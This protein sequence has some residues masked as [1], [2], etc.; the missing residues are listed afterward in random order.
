MTDQIGVLKTIPLLRQGDF[1]DC[2]GFYEAVNQSGLMELLEINLVAKGRAVEMW[3]SLSSGADRHVA[4]FL[5]PKYADVLAYAPEYFLLVFEAILDAHQ[6]G[7]A[8]PAD[9]SGVKLPAE[10]VTSTTDIVIADSV[11]VDAKST[12]DSPQEAYSAY[13]AY[14]IEQFKQR[15]SDVCAAD[16][17]PIETLRSMVNVFLNTLVY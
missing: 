17:V 7:L 12:D 4:T 10:K 8:L 9:A 5:E 3:A 6:K 1:D 2:N 11:T 15:F 14:R 13:M 16:D